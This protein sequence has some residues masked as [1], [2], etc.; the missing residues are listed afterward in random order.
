[1]Y[2]SIARAVAA[3]LADDNVV[4]PVAVIVRL[5]WLSNDDLEAWRSVRVPYLEPMI[6]CNLTRLGRFLHI[7]GFHCHG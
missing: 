7:L 2:S 5:G 1:M 4:S 6:R 3:T